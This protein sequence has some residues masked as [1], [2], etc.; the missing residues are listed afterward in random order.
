MASTS[1]GSFSAF[2]RVIIEDGGAVYG[3]AYDDLEVVHARATSLIEAEAFRGS[4]YVQSQVGKVF[5]SV[6]EDLSSGMDVLFSGTP[7]QVAGLLSFLKAIGVKDEERQ[8]LFTVDFVCHGV[9]SPLALNQ[10]IAMQKDRGFD[11]ARMNMR[12]KHYG[13]RNS[14][15]ELA[16][17]RGRV[18]RVFTRED[19]FLRAFYGNLMLRPSCYACGFKSV[20]RVSDL[21]IW[22]S[23]NAEDILDRSYETRGFTNVVVQSEK[24]LRL[25]EQAAVALSVWEVPFCRIRPKNGGMMLHSAKPNMQNEAFL[26]EVKKCGFSAAVSRFMPINPTARFREVVKKVLYRVGFLDFCSRAKRRIEGLR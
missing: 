23:W 12:S 19:G 13:Y 1:G 5:T 10:Y 7:C 26:E 2:A 11:V 22:D 24:G 15:M 8:R 4:K 16:D 3:A 14:C 21:T 17:K 6:R 9:G 18:K 20:C 25:L